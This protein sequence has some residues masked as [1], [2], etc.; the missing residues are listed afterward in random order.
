MSDG[1]TLT[2]IEGVTARLVP[3]AWE[4]A[5]ANA[6]LISENWRRRCAARSGLFDG[7][8]LLAKSCRLEGAFCS[9]E[10][11]ETSYASF[12]TH[13]DLG[14][15]DPT[16]LNAF[17]AIAPHGSDGVVLLGV[18][19]AHTAN[20]GQA[21]FPCGTPDLDDVRDGDTVDLAGSAEREFV[22]ETGMALPAG[23]Q[24]QWLLLRGKSQ[25][26]FLRPVTFPDQANTLRQDMER[27]RL[28]EIEPELAG[29]ITVASSDEIDPRSMPD[30]VQ[31]Y[32]RYAFPSSSASASSNG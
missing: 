26:A 6:A 8:V 7:R 1:F 11:F 13:K 25:A 15:H 23:A 20:A 10:L 17:A 4:W 3:F 5:Q 18:M 21:Y 2:R 30:F 29:F 28:A 12:I 27:H 16:V 9:V 14:S 19:G 32:L 24:N 31:A 22:E